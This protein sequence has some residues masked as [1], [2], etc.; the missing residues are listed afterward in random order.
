MIL[1]Y[2]P[3][4]EVDSLSV[5]GKCAYLNARVARTNVLIDQS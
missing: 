5:C 3:Q 2:R 1:R 4:R